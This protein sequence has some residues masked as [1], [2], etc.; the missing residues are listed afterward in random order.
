M[1]AQGPAER[2][3]FRR[4]KSPAFCQP[5]GF[6]FRSQSLEPIDLSLGGVRVYSH[7]RL[8]PG[9][10]LKL[11][12]ILASGPPLS[13]A[14]QVA[15]IEPLRDETP[16]RYEVGLMFHGLDQ[17]AKE[18]IASVLDDTPSVTPPRSA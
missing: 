1:S 12:L 4:T 7:F 11:A 17:A 16:A 13:V 14:A 2:R 5:L 9:E 15:W 3:K 8:S 18:A 6:A 10:R